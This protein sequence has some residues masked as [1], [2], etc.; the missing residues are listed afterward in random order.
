LKT[1]RQT[2]FLGEEKSGKNKSENKD[3]EIFLH[4]S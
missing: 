3:K 4:R 1:K 2:I